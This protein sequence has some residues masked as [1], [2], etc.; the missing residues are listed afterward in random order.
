MARMTTHFLKVTQD[1]LCKSKIIDE[2][3][4]KQHDLLN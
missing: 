2:D 3:Q 1:L 4:L